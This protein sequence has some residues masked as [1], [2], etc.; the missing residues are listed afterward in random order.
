MIT[1]NRITQRAEENFVARYVMSD[2]ALPALLIGRFTAPLYYANAE[3]FMNKVLSFVRDAP[4]NLRW[5]ILRFDSVQHVDNIAA[6]MLM[7]LA[8]RMSKQHVT[9]VFTELCAAVE[10]FLSDSGVL[11]GIGFDKV[12]PSVDAALAAYEQLKK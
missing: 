3:S 11:A 12:F 5:F 9:L 4:P 6:K 7:E 10:S 1:S 8:D 2:V